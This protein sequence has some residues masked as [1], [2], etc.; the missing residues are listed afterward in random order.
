MNASVISDCCACVQAQETAA[1][2]AEAAHAALQAAQEKGDSNEAR[3]VEAE[4]NLAAESAARIEIDQKFSEL[5]VCK[6]STMPTVTVWC[7][8]EDDH[9]SHTACLVW[10]MVFG[11]CKTLLLLA[12][13]VLSADSV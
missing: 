11:L 1:I 10:L 8:Y 2:D 13:T 7:I 9:Q 6:A 5:Q 3:A 12:D 4:Q